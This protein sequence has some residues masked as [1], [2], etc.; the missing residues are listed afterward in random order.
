MKQTIN[1]VL[2]SG[3]TYEA[4]PKI[5]KRVVIEPIDTGTT[6]EQ[7]EKWDGMKL[8]DILD[9]AESPLLK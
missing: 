1:R 4:K 6:K 7:W 8:Q 9:E 5:K 3:L 2:R